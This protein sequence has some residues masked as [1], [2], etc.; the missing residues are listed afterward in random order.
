[1]FV[2]HWSKNAR[3]LHFDSQGGSSVAD[4]TFVDQAD[5]SVT[6]SRNGYRFD[7]WLAAP[8]D[9]QI[10]PTVFKS[11]S[12]GDVTVYAKWTKVVTLV[13][14]GFADGS[15]ILTAKIKS[16]IAKFVAKNQGLTIVQCTGYTEGPTVLDSDLKLSKQRGTNACR[17]VLSLMAG[18]VSKLQTSAVQLTK[19]AA[20]NRRVSITL[21]QP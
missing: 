13:V 19:E 2:A 20:S 8:G 17:Y 14:S 1:V 6:S 18:S 11:E 5:L 16:A 9:L 21:T 7:G 12:I 3:T 4:L 10:L 15:P